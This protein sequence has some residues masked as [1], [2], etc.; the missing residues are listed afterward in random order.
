MSQSTTSSSQPLPP[1]H[2]QYQ[3]VGLFAVYYFICTIKAVTSSLLKV[4]E[5][6]STPLDLCEPVPCGPTSNRCLRQRHWFK[7][8]PCNQ[9]NKRLSCWHVSI[10][11]YTINQV[12]FAFWLVVA[13]DLLE[14]RYTMDIINTKFFL[15]HFKMAES[16]EK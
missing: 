6:I 9:E 15:V 12:I 7:T 5:M 16:F 14:D 4:C 2:I 3:Q 10:Y 1:T 13:Y 8:L 11:H